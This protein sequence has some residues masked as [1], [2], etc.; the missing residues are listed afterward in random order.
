MMILLTFS[1]RL[2][3]SSLSMLN[4]QVQGRRVLKIT[5]I[6]Y[7]YKYSQQGWES[8]NAKVKLSFFNHTQHGGNYGADVEE[9]ERSYLKSIFMYF[10]REILWISGVAEQYILSNL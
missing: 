1:G 9:T 6:C 5:C 7:F 10:Q 4:C 3:T 8:L 2:I